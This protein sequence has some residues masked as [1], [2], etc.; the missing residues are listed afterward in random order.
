M[1]MAFYLHFT[2]KAL[3]IFLVHVVFKLS[4][5]VYLVKFNEEIYLKNV[6]GIRD[7]KFKKKIVQHHVKIK[8]ERQWKDKCIKPNIENL[9]CT[10]GTCLKLG[11]K[12]F[13]S[14]G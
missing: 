9:D 2:F 11:L 10:A 7:L 1:F 5:W 3:F 6:G 12:V 14:E 8:S 13:A 4:A